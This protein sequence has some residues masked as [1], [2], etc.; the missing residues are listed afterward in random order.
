[1]SKD[2]QLDKEPEAIPEEIEAPPL[3][4][5]DEDTEEDKPIRF[6]FF[7][8]LVNMLTNIFLILVI[9]LLFFNIV[10]AVPLGGYHFQYTHTY[11]WQ[12]TKLHLKHYVLSRPNPKTLYG[13]CSILPNYT[14]DLQSCGWN[15]RYSTGQGTRTIA[16]IDVEHI[17][18]SSRLMKHANCGGL[19]R[20][21][22]RAKNKEFKRCHNNP[23]NLYP[24]IS[25]I[26]RFRGKLEFKEIPNNIA[27]YPFGKQIGFKKSLDGKYV[28]PAD[29]AKP[30]VANAYITMHNDGCI[31]LSKDEIRMYKKWYAMKYTLPAI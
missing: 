5:I 17:V 9:V 27:W 25:T 10:N 3:E 16:N 6:A 13:N 8:W 22:C 4:I 30:T 2:E 21:A 26:N 7:W 18:P 15:Y 12:T 20:A 29:F 28:E 24:A 14:V 19:S 23:H 11:G 31:T 1:M